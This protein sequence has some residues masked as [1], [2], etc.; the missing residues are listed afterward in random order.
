MVAATK[1]YLGQEVTLT[2]T[3]D[4]EELTGLVIVES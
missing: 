3:R 4:G 1:K 2:Y